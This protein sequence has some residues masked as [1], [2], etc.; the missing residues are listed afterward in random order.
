[1][2]I[3]SVTRSRRSCR[4]SLRAMAANRPPKPRCLDCAVALPDQPREPIAGYDVGGEIGMRDHLLDR[5]VN[6]E[7]AGR[8]IGDLVTALRLVHVMGRNQDGEPFGRERVN[9]TPGLA[10]RFG[11]D[12]RS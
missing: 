12:P 6:E 9:F 1:M 2:I 11:I 3:A 7:I 10:A 8:D 4:N 5:A